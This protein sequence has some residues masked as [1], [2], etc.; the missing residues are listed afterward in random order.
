LLRLD[1]GPGEKTLVVRD[2]LHEIFAGCA[3]ACPHKTKGK[4]MVRL[5]EIHGQQVSHA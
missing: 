5:T 4:L 1:V 3:E 2:L